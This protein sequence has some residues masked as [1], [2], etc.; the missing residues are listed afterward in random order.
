MLRRIRNIVRPEAFQGSHRQPPYFEGW[1]LKL[2][3]ASQTR[4]LALIPGLYRDRVA[5]NSHSFVQVFAHEQKLGRLIRFSEADFSAST[6][7][8]DTRVGENRFS[9]TGVDVNLASD[10]LELQGALTFKDLKPWPVTLASPGI[11]GWYAWVPKMECY[12]GVVSLD[13]ELS[14]VLTLNGEEIDF[15]GGHGY[16]EKDWGRSFPNCWVWMQCNHF[17]DRDGLR[18]PATSL[19]ASIAKIPWLGRSFPGFIVGLLHAGVLY[20]FTTYKSGRVTSLSAD[21]DRVVWVLENRHHRLA[22]TVDRAPTTR[23]PGPTID[24]MNRDVHET[25]AANIEIELTQRR[26]GAVILHAHGTSAGLEV[27]GDIETLAPRKRR[28]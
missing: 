27:M 18:H 22:L 1:Y 21:Q 3:N 12:H 5:T 28:A 10:G 8:F 9:R 14:G 7:S 13:H 4:R 26:G 20:R 11:M 25:L 17:T 19:T 15:T 6:E 2:V 24:G 16:I 23:L